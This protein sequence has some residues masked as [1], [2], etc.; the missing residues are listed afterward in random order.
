MATK[1]DLSRPAA[2]LDPRDTFLAAIPWTHRRTVV[3]YLREDRG[4]R[5]VRL[6]TLCKHKT[7]GHRYRT[8]RSFQVPVEIAAALGEALIAAGMGEPYGDPPEWWADFEATRK[9]AAAEEASEVDQT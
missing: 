6:R 5:F 2:A 8:V 3:V 9:A 7:D 1:T 4:R